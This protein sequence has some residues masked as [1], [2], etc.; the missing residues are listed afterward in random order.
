MKANRVLSY[1]IEQT[2]LSE[3]DIKPEKIVVHDVVN[4]VDKL[5]ISL[6][7]KFNNKYYFKNFVICC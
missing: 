6:E 2:I 7:F 1:C 3:L 5:K 4:L